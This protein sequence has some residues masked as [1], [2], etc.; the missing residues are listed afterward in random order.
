MNI[1]DVQ[2]RLCMLSAHTSSLFWVRGRCFK[3]CC[4]CLLLYR[5]ALGTTWIVSIVL[6]WKQQLQWFLLN[7]WLHELYLCR[8]NVGH[9][10][11]RIEQISRTLAFARKSHPPCKILPLAYWQLLHTLFAD[12]FGGENVLIFFIC[13]LVHACSGVESEEQP[14][15]V[16][17]DNKWTEAWIQYPKALPLQRETGFTDT[18]NKVTCSDYDQTDWLEI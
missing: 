12:N 17:Q 10:P 8:V 14:E 11:I 16:W 18:L 7:Y 9:I 3:W 1:D 13:I 6:V 15:S 2:W 5:K 4:W